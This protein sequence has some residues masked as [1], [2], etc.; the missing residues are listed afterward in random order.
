L[1]PFVL[2]G[3]ALTLQICL[4]GVCVPLNL[5]IP[6]LV[7]ML[8]RYGYLKWFRQEWVR[9]SY[10]KKQYSR[11]K[12]ETV[13]ASGPPPN[14]EVSGGPTTTEG[15][16]NNG[17]LGKGTNIEGGVAEIKGASSRIEQGDAGHTRGME[18]PGREAPNR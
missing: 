12:G 4:G 8:H 5:L 15:T 18:G 16:E 10:W 6:F 17:S 9:I 2:V 11:W 1:T 3:F 7:G 13:P 14:S